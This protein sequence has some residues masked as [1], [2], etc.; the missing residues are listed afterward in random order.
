MLHIRVVKTKGNSRAVQVYRYKNSKRVIIRHIG[1]GTTDDEILVLRELARSFIA[2]YT[3]Q[4]FLFEEERPDDKAVLLTQCNYIGFFYT[5][6]YDVLRAIQHKIG[7]TLTADALLNDLVVMR[8]VE[9]ASKLRSI[10][11]ME[12]Y[13]GIRPFT[14]RS[15]SLRPL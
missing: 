1:S 7:F 9:P 8:M 15:V 13:F 3:R 6:L 2:D 10:E 5:F 4:A 12:T 11:L 14:G